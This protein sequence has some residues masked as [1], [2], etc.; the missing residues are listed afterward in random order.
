MYKYNLSATVA[1]LEYV[2]P[3][4][5]SE[6]E[7]MYSWEQNFAQDIPILQECAFITHKTQILEC[8]SKLKK[9]EAQE[10]ERL[11]VIYYASNRLKKKKK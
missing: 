9:E 10:F 1:A 7:P 3:D 4:K 8:M 6:E 11:K 5:T 2:P